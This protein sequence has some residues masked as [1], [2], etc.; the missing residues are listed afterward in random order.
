M[1]KTILLL[2]SSSFFGIFTIA[3]EIQPNYSLDFSAGVGTISSANLMFRKNFYLGA[4]KKIIIAP[5][6]RVGFA[7]ANDINYIS[8]PSEITAEPNNID[9]FKIGNTN[10]LTTSLG[11]NLGYKVNNK[12]SVMFDIDVFGLSFGGKQMGSFMP[13]T[14]S[15]DSLLQTTANLETNPTS[16][17]ILLVGDNDRGSLFSAINVNYNLTENWGLKIGAGF[18][19]TEYTSTNKYGITNN[20]RWRAKTPQINVGVTY[21]F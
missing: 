6:F 14:N 2:I 21:N 11:I 1:K 5:G 3:Q 8:A 13:G 10:V 15:K 16:P 20:N 18:L 9:T 19:F 17:N 7:A 4:K 12:L